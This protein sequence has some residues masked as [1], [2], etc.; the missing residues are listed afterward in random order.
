MTQVDNLSAL[1]VGNGHFATTVDVTGLKQEDVLLIRSL[2]ERL[3][4]ILE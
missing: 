2:V 1:T 3:R 4:N